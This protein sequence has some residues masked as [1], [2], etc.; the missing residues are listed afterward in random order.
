MQMNNFESQFSCFVIFVIFKFCLWKI[1]LSSLNFHLFIHKMEKKSKEHNLKIISY[2]E[3]Y[4]QIY[5][6]DMYKE[7]DLYRHSYM[8]VLIEREK[9]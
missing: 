9:L 3:M 1:I 4:T 5:N 2:G 8:E 6:E 7:I